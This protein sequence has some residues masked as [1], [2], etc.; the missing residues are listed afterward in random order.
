[1]LT[2]NGQC[3]GKTSCS[4]ELTSF[5][6]VSSGDKMLDICLSPDTKQFVQYSCVEAPAVKLGKQIDLKYICM[7]LVA[8]VVIV[9]TTMLFNS[10]QTEKMGQHYDDLNLTASDYTVYVSVTA[11]HRY[12]FEERYGQEKTHSRGYWL[13][14]FI[15]ENIVMPR[16]ET[17]ARIDLVFDNKK[18]IALLESRG[19]AIKTCDY[20]QVIEIENEIEF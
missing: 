2:F 10:I 9:L 7:T 18:M 4:V 5:Y 6:Q 13:K 17:V 16:S 20:R 8:T 15:Q 19:S 3:A 14:Q 11:R 12:D 1:M